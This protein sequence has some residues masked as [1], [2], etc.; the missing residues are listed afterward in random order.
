MRYSSTPV[1][2]EH[3]KKLDYFLVQIVEQGEKSFMLSQCPNCKRHD[4]IREV[5]SKKTLEGDEK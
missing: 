2:C 5:V 4:D 1:K 3:C